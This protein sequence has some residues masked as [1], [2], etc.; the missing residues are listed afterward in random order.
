MAQLKYGCGVLIWLTGFSSSLKK[1]LFLSFENTEMI[2]IEHFKNYI[3]TGT[4]NYAVPHFLCI[5]SNN[6]LQL[7]Y[8][9]N[10]FCNPSKHFSYILILS[11]SRFFISFDHFWKITWKQVWNSVRPTLNWNLTPQFLDVWWFKMQL[12][13]ILRI[14]THHY[15]LKCALTH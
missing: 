11:F 13:A 15:S 1:Q 12:Q 4:W 5:Y 9:K 3:K 7:D 8:F 2:S 14:M 6:L 10:Y